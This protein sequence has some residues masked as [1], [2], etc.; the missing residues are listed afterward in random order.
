MERSNKNIYGRNKIKDNIPHGST[1][2]HNVPLFD[3]VVS[4]LEEARS[5]V[6]RAVNN[7]MVIAY[8]LIGREIV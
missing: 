2:R 7:N 6:V 1:K 8:W 5:K 3:R 4:I